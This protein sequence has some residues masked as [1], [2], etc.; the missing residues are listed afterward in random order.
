M[1]KIVEVNNETY[2]VTTTGAGLW[3]FAK[4]ERLLLVRASGV[5]ANFLRE[6]GRDPKIIL[7]VAQIRDEEEASVVNALGWKFSRSRAWRQLWEHYNR[8]G[9]ITLTKGQQKNW[10]KEA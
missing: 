1:E 4:I 5:M 2:R 6:H 9:I 3:G 10:N 8:R 7:S